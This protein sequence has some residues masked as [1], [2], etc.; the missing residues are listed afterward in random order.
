[1]GGDMFGSKL[2]V[3]TVSRKEYVRRTCSCTV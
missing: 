2:D 1:M 3:L